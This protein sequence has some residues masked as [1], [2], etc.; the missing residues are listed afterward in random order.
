MIWIRRALI[1]PLSLVLLVL[2]VIALVLVQIGAT[3]LN[4]GYYPEQLR[5][6]NIYEFVL[7]DLTT[8]ALD[9]A[10]ELEPDAFAEII[11]GIQE[12]PLPTLGLT[13]NDIVTSLNTA[14]PPEWV[15]GIVEQVFDELG[16]YITG[17]RDEFAVTVEA[18]DQVVAIV[19]EIKALLRK[20]DA[21]SLLFDEYVAPT[22]DDAV[23]QELP[24]GLELSSQRLQ[25]AVRRTVP[26]EWAQEQ[27]EHILDEVTPYLVGDED[28]FQISIELAD[29]AEVAL[30]EIK[31]L[32]REAEAYDL[33]YDEVIEPAMAGFVGESFELPFGFEVTRQEVVAALRRVAP[34]EW[35]QE[36][37]ED[38]IDQATP[39]ITGRADTLNV[40]IDIADNKR[41]AR[42]VLGELVA[43]RVRD[44]VD[45]VSRCGAGQIPSF[46]SSG[47]P[48]CVPPGLTVDEIMRQLQ[49][50]VV[51]ATVSVLDNVPDELRFT[52]A[53]LRQGLA[54][55][56]AEDNVDLLDDLREF[57]K[58][59]WT[60]TD[61]DLRHDLRYGFNGEPAFEN[62]R[63]DEE[64]VELLDDVRAFLA[65]GWTYTH[66]DLR[67]QILDA[68]DALGDFDQGRDI[69]GYSRSFK[70]LIYL[71]VLVL[72]VA[73][74]FLG[75]QGWSGRFLWASWALLL[76]AAVVLVVFWAGYAILGQS[77]LEE[78]RDTVIGKIALDKD[79]FKA[80]RV[81]ATTKLFEVVNSV[82][83]GFASGLRSKSLILVIVGLA[84][85]AISLSWDRLMTLAGR[86]NGPP[87]PLEESTES[88][89][90]P[91][92][93][94]QPEPSQT[95]PP[96]PD[97]DPTEPQP[98]PNI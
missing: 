13:T 30:D 28:S 23:V 62:D 32:L 52:E 2:F 19:G 5:K 70:L 60:Y 16:R 18:G 33:L 7:L 74:G 64:L 94:D 8:S 53:L 72:L 65:D 78:A 27:V 29:R 48:S 49:D 6:A 58:D 42:A 76:A 9:E 84:G 46:A 1:V 88:W 14:I 22:I 67:K 51:D 68:T 41:E 39:Y 73:I 79:E 89:T 83:D 25:A 3:F 37:A 82:A 11:D 66:E 47:L 21:Y 50:R 90:D 92:V 4:P 75:G 40:V 85:V 91:A 12:N 93:A 77:P 45:K 26:P 98:T 87:G 56:G 55:V 17:E 38:V 61:Q 15:Q 69:F 71:P 44:E 81:L 43:S 86:R 10:R 95:Q 35:V 59:G 80:T 57:V 54:Q 20:A 97:E 96:T 36:Q 31:A 34:V 24:F 63:G